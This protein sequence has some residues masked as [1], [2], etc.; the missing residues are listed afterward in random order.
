MIPLDHN[1]R[2]ILFGGKGGVGKTT[3]ASACAITL[4]RAHPEES[5]C[6]VS[7]D[8]AHSLLDALAGESVPDNLTV[9]ELDAEQELEKFQQEHGDFLLE[10]AERGTF[11]DKEDLGGFLELSMPGVDELMAFRTLASWLEEGRYRRIIIDT[12]P[13]GHTLR[14]LEMPNLLKRWLEALDTLLAKQRYIKKQFARKY[15]PD[16]LDR[17]LIELD[18]TLE[19]A[20]TTLTNPGETLFIPV[21]VAERSSIEETRGLI[22]KLEKVD[23]PVAELLFNRLL[24]QT[25]GCDLCEVRSRHQREEIRRLSRMVQGERITLYGIPQY[26]HEVRGIAALE[27]F[28]ESSAPLPPAERAPSPVGHRSSEARVERPCSE[29]QLN[30]QQRLLMVAGK[31]GVGKST[32]STAIAMYWARQQSEKRVLLFSSD[33]AHSLSQ[34][35]EQKIG[36][37]PT[38]V[39]GYE[40]L[41]AQQMSPGREYGKF[42]GRYHQELEAFLESALPNIDLTFDREVLDHFID[43]APTGLDEIIAVTELMDYMREGSYDQVVIDPA[44][45][46]HFLR[47]LETPALIENWLK[48]FF[49]LILRYREVIHFPGLNERLVSL[50][51]RTHQ[52]RDLLRDRE[53]TTAILV[54]LPTILALEET[55][56]LADALERLSVP[57]HALYLNRLTPDSGC[58]LCHHLHLEERGVVERYGQ[59][60]PSLCR[61]EVT[62]GTPLRRAALCSLGA[63]LFGKGGC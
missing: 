17:F 23:I 3:C 46:G 5:V 44:P 39:E 4:A 16:E 59:K 25:A 27:S 53:R 41:F 38:P 49:E 55:I 22:A 62:L 20:A 42:R 47:L 1:L 54:S 50:S 2:L 34:I 33:P 32:L 37:R 36:S 57:L 6:L 28:W 40:N 58:A 8:P 29:P 11:F 45:S 52:F 26:P 9:R 30:R 13:T 60:F 61:G 19:Y 35:L 43:L 14:L 31:G 7:T 51:K 48:S 12:A 63:Q 24:P 56:D 15:L 10:I 18:T 21:L